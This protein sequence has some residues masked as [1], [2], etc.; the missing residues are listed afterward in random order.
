[1]VVRNELTGLSP[2]QATWASRRIASTPLRHRFARKKASMPSIVL[3]SE[4][5]PV[6]LVAS[7]ASAQ[8]SVSAGR[9]STA[10]CNAPVT[11]IPG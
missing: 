2:W 4:S 9:P 3:P 7:A 8:R 10:N 5:A 6:V 1:M 11:A